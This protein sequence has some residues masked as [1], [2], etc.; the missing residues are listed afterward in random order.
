MYLTDEARKGKVAAH[1]RL[2][3]SSELTEQSRCWIGE[4]RFHSAARPTQ[5]C[6]NDVAALA[7]GEG[8]V[9]FAR[10]SRCDI[11]KVQA[12]TTLLL[13]WRTHNIL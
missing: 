3:E 9:Y 12:E 11:Y 4:M 6:H 13:R 1:A 5:P 2:L 8:L 7:V 10:T